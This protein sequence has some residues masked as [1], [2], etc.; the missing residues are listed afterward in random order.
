[1]SYSFEAIEEVNVRIEGGR[2]YFNPEPNF[3]GSVSMIIYARNSD[4]FAE[5]NEFTV[6]VKEFGQEELLYRLKQ[7]FPYLSFIEVAEARNLYTI[8]YEINDTVV[9]ISGLQNA[10]HIRNITV[11]DVGAISI[12]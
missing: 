1:M 12:R 9:R 7:V 10:T 2:I 6:R 4:G 8:V 11:G 3:L 5:S